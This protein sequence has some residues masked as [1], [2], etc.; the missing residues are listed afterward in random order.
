[1]VGARPQFIKAALLSREFVNA[2]IEELLVHTGQHYDQQ[3]S[4]VFFRELE[5]PEPHVDLGV[6]SGSHADQTGRMMIALEPIVR[7][8]EPAYVLVYGDT[9]S[10]LA[11]ALVAAKLQVPLAHVEAGVRSFDR[12]MPEEINRVVVDQVASVLLAPSASAADQLSREGVCGDTFVVGDLMVDL[13]RKVAA[14]LPHRPKIL[15]RFGL[16][17]GEYAV[18]TVHRA[19]NTEDEVAFA[20][21]IA[22]FRALDMPIVFPVHPRTRRLAETLAVGASD[23]IIACEPLPYLEMLGLVRDARMVLTDSGGLQKEAVVLE[24][25]CVTLRTTSEW[26]ET[27]EDGWNVLA[28]TDPAAIIAAAKRSRPNASPRIFQKG[29]SAARIVDALRRSS[30]TRARSISCAS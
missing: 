12:T 20:R 24:T 22:A 8:S 23:R 16:L 18:A 21:L 9:N 3:M 15:D 27:L 6:G 25:P 30:S 10:T 1:M 19:S 13:A 17:A 26:T 4:E 14:T 28:G 11:A 7:K 2:G 29:A 5:L